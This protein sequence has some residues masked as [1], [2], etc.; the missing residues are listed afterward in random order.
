[1]MR[2]RKIVFVMGRERETRKRRRK[3]VKSRIGV[4]NM[5]VFVSNELGW[6]KLGGSGAYLLISWNEGHEEREQ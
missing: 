6:S 3:A 2:K 5:A 1:M 4:K